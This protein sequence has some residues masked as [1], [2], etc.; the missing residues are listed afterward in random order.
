MRNHP[1]T[2]GDIHHPRSRLKTL[3]HNPRL[4]VARPPSVP[5]PRFHNLTTTNKSIPTIHHQNLRLITK[6]FWQARQ[7]AEI[8]EINGSGTPHTV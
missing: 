3:S 8:R 2:P 1:M 7:T 4:Q 5:A 6:T